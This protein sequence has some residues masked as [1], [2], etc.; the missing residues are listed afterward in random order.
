MWKRS[1]IAR[2]PL[3]IGYLLKPMAHNR[4]PLTGSFA[5]SAQACILWACSCISGWVLSPDTSEMA[6]TL[7]PSKTFCG[8]MARKEGYRRRSPSCVTHSYTQQYITILITT[9]P[10]RNSLTR[11]SVD[12]R[13]TIRLVRIKVHGTPLKSNTRIKSTPGAWLVTLRLSDK[14]PHT[15]EMQKT[16][17]K[18]RGTK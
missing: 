10:R 14:V 5:N 2:L 9:C 18:R 16:G 12:I 4:S 3:A 1:Q 6:P 7:N 11:V 13:R 15:F 17:R 8:V